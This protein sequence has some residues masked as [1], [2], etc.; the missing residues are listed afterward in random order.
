[1]GPYFC[2][3]T[4]HDVKNKWHKQSIEF[5]RGFFV[6]CKFDGDGLHT[7]ILKNTSEFQVKLILGLHTVKLSDNELGC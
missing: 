7:T 3:W 5:N 2:Y 1:M 6:Y 4:I